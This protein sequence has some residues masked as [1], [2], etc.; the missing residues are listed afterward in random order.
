MK[1]AKMLRK[2][3]RNLKRFTLTSRVVS[4]GGVGSTSL[5][6]HLE[7]GDRDRIWYHQQSKHCLH[8]DLLP[9]VGKGLRVRAC[10]L[11]GDPF[12]SVISVFR[13]GLQRRHEQAMTRSKPDYRP[14]LGHE[15][16]IEEYLS[17]GQDRFFLEQ[18]LE[19]WVGYG[20]DRVSILAVKYEALA[21]HID[22]IL[23]FLGCTRPFQLR[24]RSSTLADQPEAV[25]LGLEA[26]YGELKARIDALPSLVRVNLV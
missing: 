15:T 8:P 3:R 16:T 2:I 11:F 22:E 13:R 19:N 7:N 24:P 26:M 4:F 20:G 18:H 23:P 1:P 14:V 5:V 17:A 9:E 21:D 10:F 12:H 25:R 6:I